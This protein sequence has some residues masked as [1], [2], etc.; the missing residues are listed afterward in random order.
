MSWLRSSAYRRGR[1]DY[2]RGVQWH[3]CPYPVG[4]LAREDWQAGWADAQAA[5]LGAVGS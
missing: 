4:S 3:G 5:R 2:A 1:E